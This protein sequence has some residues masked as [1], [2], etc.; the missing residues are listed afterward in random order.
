MPRHEGVM[1]IPLYIQMSTVKFGR[2]NI[3]NAHLPKQISVRI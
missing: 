3:N 1:P 2:M